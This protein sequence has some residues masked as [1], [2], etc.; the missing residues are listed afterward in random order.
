MLLWGGNGLLYIPITQLKP[1]MKLAKDVI[2][3]DGRLLLL[4]GYAIKPLYIRKLEAFGI[5]DVYIEENTFIPVTGLEEE[6]VYN[7]AA[8]MIKNIFAI[9]SD[10]KSPD[11]KDVKNTVSDI[12]NRVMEKETIMLQLTGI[13]DIDN[14]TFLHSV[15]VCI[16]STIIGKKLGYGSDSLMTLGMGAVL[17]DIGKCKVSAELLS[18][19]DK[20]NNREYSEMKLHSTLGYEILKNSYG[21]NTK[22]ANIALQHHEK[23]DGTGYPLGLSSNRI[24]PLA[25]IVSIADVYDA[26]TSDRVYKKK[27]LPHKAADY[28]NRNAGKLFDPHIVELFINNIA[29][30]AEGT[31]VL[32]SSGELGSVLSP[33]RTGR[34]RQMINVFSNKSGPPVLRPY[35]LDLNEHID[36]DI[37]EIF[38]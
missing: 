16:Y 12:I 28:I 31:L 33:G 21:F 8:S 37:V 15:D 24:D 6:K 3:S 23:W 14:Y 35:I 34:S 13:K 36:I 9:T 10:G 2:L 11:V 18:K 7:H 1:G 20:L 30:Y 27:E 5:T 17:H 22:I 4:A 32:L 38:I 19:P 26:L 29:A 25:R